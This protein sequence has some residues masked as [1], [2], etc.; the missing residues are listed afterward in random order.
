MWHLSHLDDITFPPQPLFLLLFKLIYLERSFWFH[1]TLGKIH[2]LRLTDKVTNGMLNPAKGIRVGKQ[3][4]NCLFKIYFACFLRRLTMN[5]YRKRNLKG[6]RSHP[7]EKPMGWGSWERAW[8]GFQSKNG[9]FWRSVCQKCWI[10]EWLK[11]L[12]VLCN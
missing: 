9:Y 10:S 11:L 2:F 12:L 3:R 8:R 1:I 6:F 4:E 7:P 5:C